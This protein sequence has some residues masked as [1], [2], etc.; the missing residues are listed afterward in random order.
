MTKRYTL[1]HLILLLAL[2]VIPNLLSANNGEPGSGMQPRRL[3]KADSLAI[4]MGHCNPVTIPEVDCATRTVTLSAYINWLFTG[5]QEPVVANWNTGQVAHKITVT[6]PGLW[7]WDASNTGCEPN[8]WNT[9]YDQ[10]GAFFLGP[11]IITGPPA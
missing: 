11:L 4:A 3:T 1:F 9:D 7:N 2:F 8:H 10:Q 6:P 5:I